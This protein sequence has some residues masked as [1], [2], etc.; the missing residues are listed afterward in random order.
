M[1][2]ENYKQIALCNMGII[3]ANGELDDLMEELS[4]I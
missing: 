3:E 4:N 2:N 1:G